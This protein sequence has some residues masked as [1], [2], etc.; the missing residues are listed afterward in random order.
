M[1]QL[2]ETIPRYQFL[3]VE[4]PIH[5]QCLAL[6]RE[7]VP[8]I[9]VSPCAVP[10]PFCHVKGVQ[11]PFRNIASTLPWFNDW[12]FGLAESRRPLLVFCNFVVAKRISLACEVTTRG[13]RIRNPVVTGFMHPVPVRP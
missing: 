7:L 2:L 8:V 1:V 13:A 12:P 6:F 3:H 10:L 9:E 11:R 4:G 5:S